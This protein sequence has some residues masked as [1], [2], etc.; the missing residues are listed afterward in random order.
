[1]ILAQNKVDVRLPVELWQ[2]VFARVYDQRTLAH[3][4]LLHPILYSEGEKA[5]YRSITLS[6]DSAIHSLSESITL[7]RSSPRRAR[8]VRA[9]HVHTDVATQETG[10]SLSALLRFLSELR[11]LTL[12]CRALWHPTPWWNYGACFDVLAVR[13][14][15][16]E[17]LTTGGPPLPT[18]LAVPTFLAN[19]SQT[20]KQLDIRNAS[21][22]PT[23]A[24][25]VATYWQMRLPA[26]RIL[27]CQ[28]VFLEVQSERSLPRLTRLHL[29]RAGVGGLGRA[30]ALVG[31]GLVSLRLSNCETRGE[32]WLVKDVVERFPRLRFLHTK[33][34][35]VKEPH[36]VVHM[37]G[38][39]DWEA[40]A[41]LAPASATSSRSPRRT[42]L[43]IMWNVHIDAQSVDAEAHLDSL[44]ARLL[45]NWDPVL[46]HIAY[47][48]AGDFPLI[49]LSLNEDK[50][51]VVRK[52]GGEMG[53]DHWK[54]GSFD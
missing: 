42:F 23:D 2:A 54:Y 51:G 33:L 31:S 1:M 26:L 10:L 35:T 7:E 49:C 3:L 12:N 15:H 48:R 52:E 43:T 37:G 40:D 25:V 39:I 4:L 24:E 20:L 14:P 6:K 19:H 50:M 47:R 30:A 5:L 22:S 28:P 41:A 11:A 17:R 13:F 36:G 21:D 45:A 46:G 53:E 44:A 18:E 38:L 32:R 9:L 29:Y 34:F 16:L 27:E 8:L